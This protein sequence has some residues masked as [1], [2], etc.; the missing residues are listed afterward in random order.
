[1][2]IVLSIIIPV[3]NAEKYLKECLDSVRS[4]TFKE[5][6]CILVDD[7]SKDSSGAI[8]DLYYEDSSGDFCFESPYDL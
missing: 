7:G 2:K 1:M 6:E 3:Y 4:L 5:W 8:C